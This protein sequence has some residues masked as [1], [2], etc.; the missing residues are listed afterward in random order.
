MYHAYKYY[1][2]RQNRNLQL[3][4]IELEQASTFYIESLLTYRIRLIHD[5]LKK[6]NIIQPSIALLLTRRICKRGRLI[7]FSVRC[8]VFWQGTRLAA[9]SEI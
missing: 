3:K 2:R 6:K 7:S 4:T 5:A 8:K 1:K 9:G